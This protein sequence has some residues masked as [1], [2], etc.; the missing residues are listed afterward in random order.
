MWR[1]SRGSLYTLLFPYFKSSWLASHYPDGDLSRTLKSPSRVCS[2]AGTLFSEQCNTIVRLDALYVT[3][4]SWLAQH[5]TERPRLNSKLL[6]TV[7]HFFIDYWVLQIRFFILIISHYNKRLEP[8]IPLSAQLSTQVRYYT[9]NRFYG[10]SHK[11]GVP[12]V[13]KNLL[14]FANPTYSASSTALASSI[15]GQ[16]ISRSKWRNFWNT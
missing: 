15:S 14:V 5:S 1:Y 8:N 7:N 9:G 2:N 12:I 4:R 10:S 16:N 11:S 13:D 3:H 6:T